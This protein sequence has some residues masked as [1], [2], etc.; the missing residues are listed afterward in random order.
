MQ[1]EINNKNIDEKYCATTAIDVEIFAWQTL[2]L[3]S[4]TRLKNPCIILT[5]P[6][7][8]HINKMLGYGLNA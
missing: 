3:L 4:I 8:K 6:I 5:D 7:D 2:R 1:N